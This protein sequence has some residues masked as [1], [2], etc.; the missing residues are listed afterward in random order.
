MKALNWFRKT[1]I[2]LDG[3]KKIIGAFCSEELHVT[4]DIGR[5]QFPPSRRSLSGVTAASLGANDHI[6]CGGIANQTH[7]LRLRMS[8]SAR[9]ED[10]ARTL[11]TCAPSL[12]RSAELRL[13]RAFL[14]RSAFNTVAVV[15]PGRL[16]QERGGVVSARRLWL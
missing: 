15:A 11:R 16:A 10:V 8:Y 9:T 12:L 6:L 14:A 4:N 3:G 5:C 13:P 7:S 1:A 2:W